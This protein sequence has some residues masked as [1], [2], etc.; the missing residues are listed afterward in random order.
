[1]N[2]NDPMMM[3]TVEELIADDEA[4]LLHHNNMEAIMAYEQED[5]RIAVFVN[6]KGDNQSRPDYTGRGLFNGQEFEVSLWNS[7]S[8]SG[9]EYMSGRIQKPY[10]GGSASTSSTTHADDVPF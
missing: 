6:D 3:Y 1:M 5:G 8:K 2:S 7:T 9:L 10:N 4:A